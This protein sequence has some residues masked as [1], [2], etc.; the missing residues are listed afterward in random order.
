VTSQAGIA[1]AGA[2][3]APVV[4]FEASGLAWCAAPADA[5]LLRREIAQRLDALERA[6]GAAVL[7]H[8]LLRTVLRVPLPDGRRVI[9]KR[10]R[11]AGLADAL[12]YL[13]VPSRA[14]TEWRVG[15]ALERAGLDTSVPLAFA[16]GRRGPWLRAA[17]LVAREIDPGERLDA[18]L[19]RL[20]TPE[21]DAWLGLL[22]E[23]VRRLHDAGF[24]HRDLHA[25]NLL[26]GG[27]PAPL[28]LH[29]I[30]LHSVRRRRRVSQRARWR[31]LVKLLHSLRHFTTP[32]ERLRLAERYAQ[33]APANTRVGRLAAQGALAARLDDALARLERVRLRSRSRRCLVRSTR[34]D[35]VRVAGCRVH[36]LRS[37]AAA[38]AVA[39]AG[40]A[41]AEAR[42]GARA[43]RVVRFREPWWARL[44]GRTR[45]RAVWLA[46][47]GLRVRGVE[48][49]EPLALVLPG[50]GAALRD[51]C[52]VLEDLGAERRA[53]RVLAA[54][55]GGPP[56]AG[57]AALRRALV[58]AAAAQLRRLHAAGVEP[59][60]VGA[61]H[62]LVLGPPEAPRL[63]YAGD[64]RVRFPRRLSRRRR[65]A[66]LARLAASLPACVS[67]TDRLR[68][69]RAY[70][71]DDPEMQAD[72][73]RWL[74]RIGAAAREPADRGLA[75]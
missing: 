74:R 39:L 26:L 51:A 36:H 64:G 33:A 5:E 65:M 12:K 22:A 14:R 68:F 19:D 13:L 37:L 70:A 23:R 48:S 3:D 49:A 66:S 21:R 8:N 67:R 10:Y 17:A 28:R 72:W 25:G 4:R 9:V 27:T 55:L 1:R 6:P 46:G 75:R 32:A 45:A 35:L 38:D 52:V 61:S 30:D 63:A 16:E 56:A 20:P 42:L 31:D 29:V 53:D 44:R 34:F 50:P 47:N 54:R 73:K 15:R 7:K 2:R 11:T 43:L 62:W 60:D 41:D 59:V 69:L 71:A 40:S 58:L 24:A 18:W 57:R